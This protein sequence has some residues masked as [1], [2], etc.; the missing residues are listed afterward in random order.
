MW[1]VP[2]KLGGGSSS[3]NA[4]GDFFRPLQP[5]PVMSSGVGVGGD[6]HFNAL[7][8][9]TGSGVGCEQAVT[10][11]GDE[12][13]PS[14]P[15]SDL[16][17]GQAGGNVGVAVSPGRVASPPDSPPNHLAWQASTRGHDLGQRQ[18]VLFQPGDAE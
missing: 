3:P 8:I 14:T 7:L 9:R 2:I 10:L 1:R 17:G 13:L 16:D 11:A 4:D 5:A 15:T 6:V 12:S 18:L